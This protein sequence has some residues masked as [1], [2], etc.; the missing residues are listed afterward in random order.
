[1]GPEAKSFLLDLGQ[2]LRQHTGEPRST[3]YL[4]QRISMAVQKSNAVAMMGSLP[5]G[6]EL[7]KLLQLNIVILHVIVLSIVLYGLSLFISIFIFFT[8]FPFIVCMYYFAQLFC[9]LFTLLYSNNN[10]IQPQKSCMPN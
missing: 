6:K 3:S 7:D 9:I 10:Y 8:F 1:M 4:I 2:G 5:H